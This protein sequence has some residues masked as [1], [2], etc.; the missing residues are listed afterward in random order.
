MLQS[1]KERLLRE[2]N[3]VPIKPK[4]RRLPQMPNDKWQEMINAIKS[5]SYPNNSISPINTLI[6]EQPANKER[7]Y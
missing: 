3:K 2:L 4:K 6:N 5:N 7:V 1:A